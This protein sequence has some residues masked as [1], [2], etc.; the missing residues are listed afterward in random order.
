MYRNKRLGCAK[1][2]MF[3]I[4]GVSALKQHAFFEFLDW[5]ALERLQVT[6]PFNFLSGATSGIPGSI[7]S[8]KA[9]AAAES[10]GFSLQF[11]D[12][13]FTNQQLSLSVLED[14]L[15]SPSGG[16][17]MR[18]GTISRD[19]GKNN[20]MYRIMSVVPNVN[21][22]MRTFGVHQGHAFFTGHT[23]HIHS[24]FCI[25]LPTGSA[26]DT[27][28]PFSDFDYMKDSLGYTQDQVEEFH[29]QL[30]A[31]MAK[32][33]KKK[34]LKSKKE[35]KSQAEALKRAAALEQAALQKAE[36]ERQR[37]EQAELQARVKAAHALRQERL[38]RHR[39]DQ[40][41]I[42]EHNKKVLVYQEELSKQQK[43]LKAL[44]KKA[45]DIVELQEKIAT[46]KAADKNYKVTAEQKQKLDR[47]DAIETEIE[48]VEE[49]EKE[50]LS[51]CPGELLPNAVLEE[52][53]DIE[54]PGAVLTNG[55]SACK[56]GAAAVPTAQPASIAAL[57]LPLR[58]RT[59]SADVTTSAGAVLDA[60]TV[61]EVSFRAHKG[62]A[63]NTSSISITE[64]PM[65]SKGSVDGRPSLHIGSQSSAESPTVSRQGSE[66]QYAT[67]FSFSPAHT[68]R[69]TAVEPKKS[70]WATSASTGS[71]WGSGTNAGADAPVVYRAPGSGAGS[72]SK[73]AAASGPAAL[74]DNWRAKR[75]IPGV[76][77]ATNAP[78]SLPQTATVAPSTSTNSTS[79]GEWRTS[80]KPAWGAPAAS[81]SSKPIAGAPAPS[82]G[83]TSWS[84]LLGKGAASA[85]TPVAAPAPT[86]VPSAAPAKVESGA[87][88]KAAA[89]ADEWVTLTTTKKKVAKKI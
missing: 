25:V 31:K 10:D 42:D 56:N 43:K 47:L 87:L 57:E 34:A 36:E 12:A 40:A 64:V 60:A 85:P 7:V 65:N 21:V 13:E 75:A 52:V 79:N 89:P 32:A 76:S 11:F 68:S 18:S 72:P 49:A 66:S 26:Q 30:H 50:V 14:T 28:D 2:T 62:D 9:T 33:Q 51:T 80:T 37:K 74:D 15:V 53:P 19:E 86:P 20:R 59:A 82:T 45:R 58:T 5:N 77:G 83:T 71:G 16:T 81:I 4:G 69:T 22:V 1:S 63:L 88:A 24:Q 54:V 44:R 61:M 48:E 70:F 6:P 38:R 27:T 73:P 46:Q 84:S 8:D 23:G 3:S 29:S 41:R 17:P 39:E 67:P 55:R 35:E 78:V